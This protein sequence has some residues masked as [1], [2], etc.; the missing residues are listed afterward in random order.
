[1]GM[2]NAE[3]ILSLC[4]VA[5]IA[6]AC[7]YLAVSSPPSR[8]DWPLVASLLL[9]A[10]IELL[11]LLILKTPEKLLVMKPVVFVCEALMPIGWALY[12]TGLSGHSLYNRSPANILYWSGGLLLLALA[13]LPEGGA[14]IFSPDFGSELILF[15]RQVGFYFYLLMTVYL[16]VALV[17]LERSFAALLRRD[18]W[19]LKFE[20]LGLGAIMSMQLVYYSQGLIYKTIDMSLVT[21]RTAAVIFGLLLFFY[22]RLRRGH[23]LRLSLSRSAAFRS[24]VL[25][26]VSSYLIVIGLAGEGLRYLGPS[27]NRAFIYALA[28]FGGVALCLMILSESLR[29]KTKVFLHK[30]FYQQKYDY[31]ILWMEMTELL[32]NAKNAKALYPAIVEMYCQTFALQRGALYLQKEGQDWLELVAVYAGAQM[33]GRI[34]SNGSLVRFLNSKKWVFNLQENAGEISPVD[35]AQLEKHDIQIVVPLFFGQLFGGAVVLSRQI[36]TSE[37]LI[38]EDYD[39]MKIIGRQASAVL[40]NERLSGQLADQREMAAVGKVS[41]FVMHDLKNLVTNLSLVVENAQELIRD[42]RFQ[43]DMLET[44]QNSVQ[45]MNSLIGRLKKVGE[46]TPLV[47]ESCNLKQ[48]ASE[49]S[50][51]IGNDAVT[52]SGDDVEAMV[53]RVEIGKV[54]TN[55][56]LNG[57]EAS[58]G[59]CN[60]QVE[61]A[62][63]SGPLLVCRDEGCGMSAEF[64]ASNLFHPFETTKKKGLGIGL[65]Q[66][67][68]IVEAHGG[69]I[70]VISAVGKGSEF[71]VYLPPTITSKGLPDGKTADR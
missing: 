40:F 23:P 11:D 3:L 60:V 15:L 37:P 25:L 8:R 7:L 30:N 14:L 63:D 66:C 59:N 22:S 36:D 53:D 47:F 62:H 43:H 10:V 65:Y 20:V 29:R 71:R 56:I 4:A 13:I 21:A 70:E 42:P 49:T 33:P 41:A 5:M 57:I 26:V 27:P 2:M 39:L 6:V 69:R 9:A 55:L 48:L 46:T 19:R 54:V 64:I 17:M 35:S 16:L 31:R 18:R 34:D 52:V 58:K 45:R 61:V 44:L 68:Q 24:V 67:R 32:E 50:G 1:M 12:A 28:L 51:E 38:Y